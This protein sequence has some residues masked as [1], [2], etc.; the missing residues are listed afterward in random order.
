[1]LIVKNLLLKSLYKLIL[2][3]YFVLFNESVSCSS[4]SSSGVFMTSKK[5]ENADEFK[6]NYDSD[7]F[8]E[9]G[10]KSL[11]HFTGYIEVLA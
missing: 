11:L 8:I 6:K 4:V 7:E 10:F 5:M 2:C 1:M 3:I 9:G